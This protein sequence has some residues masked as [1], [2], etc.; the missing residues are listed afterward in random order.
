MAQF[1]HNGAHAAAGRSLYTGIT[2]MNKSQSPP[3]G[4]TDNDEGNLAAPQTW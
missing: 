4:E 1:N 3:I 2:T